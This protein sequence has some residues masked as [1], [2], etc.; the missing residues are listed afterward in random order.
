MQ[1]FFYPVYKIVFVCFLFVYASDP[2]LAET[3]PPAPLT[4]SIP[5][6][7]NLD[8][9]EQSFV[10]AVGVTL[11]GLDKVT[12]RVFELKGST[13]EKIQFGTLEI[14]IQACYRTPLDETHDSAVY[15]TIHDTP[16]GRASQQIFSGWMFASSP[17]LS[18]FAHPVYDVWLKTCHLPDAK[19]AE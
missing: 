10:K 14:M 8:L 3:P 4:E 9:D 1:H 17:G 7:E 15:L 13:G 11:Q 16:K 5:A 19:P 18:S 2:S 6:P 12:T